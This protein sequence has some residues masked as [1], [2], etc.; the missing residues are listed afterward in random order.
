[1]TCLPAP[2]RVYANLTKGGDAMSK[3][4]AFIYGVIAYVVFLGTFLYA[5][6][7]V[8]NM[9]VPKSLDS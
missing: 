4:L 2:S 1:M 7:F 3:I 5:I 6:G 8:G 9:V